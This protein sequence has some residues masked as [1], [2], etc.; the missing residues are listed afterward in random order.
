[1]ILPSIW[2]ERT[3]GVPLRIGQLAYAFRTHVVSSDHRTDSFHTNS[4][5]ITGRQQGIKCVVPVWQAKLWTEQ[6]VTSS[7]PVRLLPTLTS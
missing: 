3:Y 2:E 4:E 1:M 7:A 5:L 6:V